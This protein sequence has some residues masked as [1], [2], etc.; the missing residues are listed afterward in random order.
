M[1]FVLGEVQNIEDV[2]KFTSMEDQS[3]AAVGT[4]LTDKER[5]NG[6]EFFLAKV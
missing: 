3:I 1:F 6:L 2:S 5:G 4:D